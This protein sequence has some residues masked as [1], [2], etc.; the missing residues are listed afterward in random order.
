M[1]FAGTVTE[2]AITEANLTL[3]AEAPEG[4]PIGTI[5]Y[6]GGLDC[7]GSSSAR[8]A[9]G[10]KY[11]FRARIT[12]GGGCVDGGPIRLTHDAAAG[13]GLQMVFVE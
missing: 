13:A 2:D 9:S 12:R 7:G 3:G 5:A 6:S 1:Q 4:S 10:S 8:E 11:A